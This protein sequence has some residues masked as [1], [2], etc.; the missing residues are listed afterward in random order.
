[1]RAALDR[2]ADGLVGQLRQDAGEAVATARY[3]RHLGTTGRRP[4]DR[5]QPG[6]IVTGKTHVRSERGFVDFNFMTKALQTSNT[7]PKSRLVAHGTGRRVYVDMAHECV[8]SDRLK[9]GVIIA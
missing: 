4:A 3:E 9:G 2:F 6:G 5:R 7:A 8:V 1:M